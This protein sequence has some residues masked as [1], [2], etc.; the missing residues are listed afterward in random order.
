[1]VICQLM[2]YRYSLMAAPPVQVFPHA[3][4]NWTWKKIKN[5][6]GRLPIKLTITIN[7]LVNIQRPHL[8]YSCSSTSLFHAV[9]QK[10]IFCCWPVLTLKCIP[11]IDCYDQTILFALAYHSDIGSRWHWNTFQGC[12]YQKFLTFPQLHSHQH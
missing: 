6:V 11:S 2:R 5:H 10:K 12:S 4:Q 1:M 8:L 7:C 3:P 9:K